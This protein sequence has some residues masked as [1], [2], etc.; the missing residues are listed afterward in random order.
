MLYFE[1]ATEATSTASC[2]ICSDMSAF[3]MTAFRCSDIF[4]LS[5]GVLSVDE[6]TM[7][8]SYVSTSFGKEARVAIY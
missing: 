5:T 2:C 1:S 8:Q 7:M 6:K 4:E 3:L